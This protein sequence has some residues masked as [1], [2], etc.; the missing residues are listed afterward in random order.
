MRYA[1][2]RKNILDGD[3]IAV[4]NGAGTLD[5]MVR[6]FT[7]SK[8]SHTGIALWLDGG[9]WIVELNAGNNHA[10]PLSQLPEFDVFNCPVDRVAVRKAALESLR[11]EIPYSWVTVLAAGFMD[12]FSLRHPLYWDQG[13]VCSSYCVDLYERAGWPKASEALSPGDLC[14]KL[15]CTINVRQ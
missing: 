10:K 9:L 6:F 2:A 3:L 14:S 8:Y 15:N 12:V 11:M 5:R 1:K 4:V 13:L 7:R